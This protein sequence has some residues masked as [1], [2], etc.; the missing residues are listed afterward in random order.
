MVFALMSQCFAQTDEYFILASRTT[1]RAIATNNVVSTQTTGHVVRD[2]NLRSG[3]WGEG[4]F[5]GVNQDWTAPFAAL[6]QTDWHFTYNQTFTLT[7]GQ[8]LEVTDHYKFSERGSGGGL[9]TMAGEAIESITWDYYA[10]YDDGVTFNYEGP[11]YVGRTER[12]YYERT[13]NCEVKSPESTGGAG[14]GN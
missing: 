1:A 6:Y 2:E 9:T 10:S 11:V 3:C 7:S 13:T 5:S 8:W 14:G 4:E 12:K